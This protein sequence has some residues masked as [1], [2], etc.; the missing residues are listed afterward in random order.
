MPGSS[1]AAGEIGG[2]PSVV[3]LEGTEPTATEGRTDEDLVQLARW[4]GDAAVVGLGESIHGTHTLHRLAHRIFQHL[5]EAPGR[6]GFEV[7]ALEIDQAH[8]AMLDAYVQ[9]DRDDLD[10][11]MAGGWWAQTIFYDEA[12]AELLRW[13]RGY[14]ETAARPLHVAGFDAKQPQLAADRLLQ[15]IGALDPAASAKV[16]A[17]LSQA[18]APGW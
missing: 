7:F 13:M 18:L 9:G 4:I 5:A 6:E 8:A 12:L 14:N 11:L 17:L 10:R 3:P 1:V 15:A 2:L 16:Q